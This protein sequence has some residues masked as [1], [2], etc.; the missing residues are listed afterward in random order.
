MTKLP[1]SMRLRLALRVLRGVNGLAP[2]QPGNIYA[3]CVDEHN[4]PVLQ[5]ARSS[6][7][8]HRDHRIGDTAI[9]FFYAV[10]RGVMITPD[11][12]FEHC[13]ARPS[14]EKRK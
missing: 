14:R 12:L 3:I 9:E 13:I 4:T 6:V 2:R 8:V 7:D 10:Q 5:G 1:F 11:V